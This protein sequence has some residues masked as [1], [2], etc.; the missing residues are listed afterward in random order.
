MKVFYCLTH[1][2]KEVFVKNQFYKRQESVRNC[3]ELA[4]VLNL[5]LPL[6]SLDAKVDV[7]F[8]QDL[9]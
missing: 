7:K 6:L 2:V 9:Q 5:H 1:Y 4:V 3:G 8:V